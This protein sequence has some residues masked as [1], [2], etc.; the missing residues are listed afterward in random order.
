MNK[1][2]PPVFF[3]TALFSSAAFCAAQDTGPLFHA[4]E[5]D[6]SLSGEN[7]NGN[8]DSEP[9]QTVIHSTTTATRSTVVAAPT[10]APSPTATPPDVKTAAKAATTK[11]V[12]PTVTTTHKSRRIVSHDRLEHN[13]AGGSVAINYFITRF[14]GIALEGDFLGGNPYNTALTGNLI[15][16]YPFEFGASSVTTGYSKDGK[17]GKTAMT[18]PTWGI[19]PYIL[20][21]GGGQWDGRG[22]GIADVGGGLEFRFRRHYSIF[23]EGRWIIHDSRESYAAE[24]VGLGYSF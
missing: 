24:N 19:A 10:T 21:G 9:Q 17:D 22:E 23:V 14:I 3:L 13:A 2:V 1:L 15:F 8:I 16:R 12:D 11:T 4:N 18:G 20:I 6:V 7:A 5:L